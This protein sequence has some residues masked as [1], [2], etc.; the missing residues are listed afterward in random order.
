MAGRGAPISRTAAGL[1]AVVVLVACSQ[2]TSPQAAKPMPQNLTGALNGASYEIDVPANWNGTL[3]LYSHG[4]VAPGGSNGAQAAPVDFAR[5]WLLEHGY[6]AAGSAYSS[7]GW[8]LEDAFK[9][10][11]AL[12]DY[13]STH[14]GKPKRVVAW[15]ASL[16]G[17]IAAGLVQLHPDRF[18]AA[19][20][21]CGVLSGGIA[22]WNAELDS[23]RSGSHGYEW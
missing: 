22:T 10:Q 21:L 2:S 17:I 3:F 16:G 15:G 1:L 18:A 20:S 11:I 12:L 6:A 9:D 5:S 7:T 23:V 19:M 14:V 8:A 4:Y 13:L